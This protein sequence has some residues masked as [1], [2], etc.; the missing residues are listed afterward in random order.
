MRLGELIQ[1][2]RNK[3]L[4]AIVGLV[5]FVT[6]FATGESQIRSSSNWPPPTR[7]E[8][9]GW[10]VDDPS[11]L[12][13]AARLN[14]PAT[15]PVLWMWAHNDQFAYA[16]D[17]HNLLVYIPWTFL[18]FWLWYFVA[19]QVGRAVSNRDWTSSAER[20]LVYSTQVL[21]TAELL[22]VAI[23]TSGAPTSTPFDVVSFWTWAFATFAGWVNLIWLSQRD[24]SGA[25][26]P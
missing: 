22:Y 19:C 9:G 20:V 6:M 24:R 14:L 21:V 2:P 12:I 1:Q 17:D 11:L 8:L 26:L 15:V 25:R 3:L 23:A 16:F 13:C 10:Q 5:A 4:V 7:H 18:V